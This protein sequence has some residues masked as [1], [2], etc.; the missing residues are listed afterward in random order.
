MT[1][2]WVFLHFGKYLTVI[3]IIL[4]GSTQHL[5]RLIQLKQEVYINRILKKYNFFSHC[6]KLNKTKHLGLLE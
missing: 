5:T 6:L 1:V 3:Y 4:E 2:M